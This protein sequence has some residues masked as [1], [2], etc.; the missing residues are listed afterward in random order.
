M[1]EIGES[2]KSRFNAGIAQVYRL[3]AAQQKLNEARQAPLAFNS[4]TQQFGYEMM[5]SSILSMYKEGKPKFNPDEIKTCERF[6]KVIQEQM[7]LHPIFKTIDNQERNERNVV[8]DYE[9][10]EKIDKL[11]SLFED[12]VRAFLDEH[13]FNSPNK[14][15]D[16]YEDV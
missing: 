10:W 11:I 7:K 5:L 14:G 2:K 15:D 8:V 12:D 1:V 9:N 4:D 6:I 3:D 16:D 13:D